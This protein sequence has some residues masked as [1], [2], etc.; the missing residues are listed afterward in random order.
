MFD[1]GLCVQTFWGNKNWAVKCHRM[2]IFSQLVALP[3]NGLSQVPSSTFV[4]NRRIGIFNRNFTT[5]AV[6]VDEIGFETNGH[7]GVTFKTRNHNGWYLAQLGAVKNIFSFHVWHSCWSKRVA[8]IWCVCW[9]VLL[10]ADEWNA[11]APNTMTIHSPFVCGQSQCLARVR[12]SLSSEKWIIHQCEE[13]CCCTY[14][15]FR[16]T[17]WD[18]LSRWHSWEINNSTCSS[19]RHVNI[20]LSISYRRPY[21]H[22]ARWEWASSIYVMCVCVCFFSSSLLHSNIK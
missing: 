10:P 3:S 1:A 11:F 8:I 2:W 13:V 22:S 5:F 18:S 12:V 19:V 16:H 20:H 17:M 6:E 7:P 9:L 4:A 14:P 21:H 15:S